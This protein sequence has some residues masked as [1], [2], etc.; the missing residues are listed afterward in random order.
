M[1]SN[2]ICFVETECNIHVLKFNCNGDGLKFEKILNKLKYLWKLDE[3]C[4]LLQNVNSF[5]VIIHKL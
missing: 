1:K 2:F 5:K 4:I 3:N